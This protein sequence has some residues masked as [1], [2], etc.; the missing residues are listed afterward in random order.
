MNQVISTPK[1]DPG[2]S[3]SD[4]AKLKKE[5]KDTIFPLKNT[6]PTKQRLPTFPATSA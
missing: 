2:T 4:N 1:H 6:D 3:F 5:E